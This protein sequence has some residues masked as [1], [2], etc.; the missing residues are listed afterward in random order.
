[1]FSGQRVLLT[2]FAFV[3]LCVSTARTAQGGVVH[4]S[5]RGCFGANCTPESTASL[6]DLTFDG[7]CFGCIFEPQ[8]QT[9]GAFTLGNSNAANFNG[10]SFTLWVRFDGPTFPEITTFTATLTAGVDA[11][12]EYLLI[13][14]IDSPKIFTH[15][16]FGECS[17]CTSQVVPLWFEPKDLILRA[18]QSATLFAE[19]RVI[20]EPA[21]IVLLGTGLAGVAARHFKR[22]KRGR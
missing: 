20:P 21:T 17:R 7:G 22:R 4:G 18:G 10:Q 14:F 1:M 6:L 5:T 8:L 11:N 13:D 9:I 19:S 12:G 15:I 3:I 2:L 16:I